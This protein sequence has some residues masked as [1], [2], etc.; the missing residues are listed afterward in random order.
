MD[1]WQGKKTGERLWL[2]AGQ[3]QGAATACVGPL[4]N[5]ASYYVRCYVAFIM[6]HGVAFIMHLPMITSHT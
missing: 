6:H 5:T 4:V 3:W 1:W 2:M